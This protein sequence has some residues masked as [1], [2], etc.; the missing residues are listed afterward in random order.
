MTRDLNRIYE[1][2]RARPPRPVEVLILLV[3]A[4]YLPAFWLAE[5]VGRVRGHS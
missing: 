4:F 3:V 2:S 5:R 1:L